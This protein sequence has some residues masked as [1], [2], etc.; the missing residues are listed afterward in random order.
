MDTD[1]QGLRSGSVTD[2]IIGSATEVLNSLG[3][4][5][6]ERLYE[7]ALVVELRYRNTPCQQQPRFNVTYRGVT[8]GE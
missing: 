4:G 5:L 7:N 2:T 8:V 1:Q 6:L 3:H